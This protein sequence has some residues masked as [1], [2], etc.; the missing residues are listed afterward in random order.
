MKLQLTTRGHSRR[1]H[2]KH[3]SGLACRCD[4]CG[5]HDFGRRHRGGYASRVVAMG[6]VWWCRYCVRRLGDPRQLEPQLEGR[7]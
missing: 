5:W 2:A 1:V 7:A 3:Y 6:D 4:V